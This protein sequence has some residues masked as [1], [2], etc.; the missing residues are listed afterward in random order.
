MKKF[1]LP[2]EPGLKM[3]PDCNGDGFTV[4]IY[5]DPSG[6]CDTCK[7]SGKVPM[8]EEDYQDE[9]ENAMIANSEMNDDL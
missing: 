5:S 4:D 7:G 6:E 8:T 3:C 2:E 9:Y 1:T